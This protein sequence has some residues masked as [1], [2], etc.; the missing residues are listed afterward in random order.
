[1][2]Q[3][4]IQATLAD[5]QLFRGIETPTLEKIASL[6][7]ARILADGDAVVEQGD[8]SDSFG[9]VVEGSFE[10]QVKDE[11]LKQVRVL[12]TL[13]RGDTFGEI[14]LL[15]ETRRPASLVA[16]G[17]GKVILFDKDEFKGLV[18]DH[19]TIPLGLAEALA[20]RVRHLMR[21]G[22][23][24]TVRI[25]DFEP[26]PEVIRKLPEQVIRN[27]KVLPLKLEGERLT[28]GVVDPHD[29][30]V[31]NT[32]AAFAGG[33]EHEWV[34][35]PAEDLER[36]FE[37]D[38][39]KVFEVALEE[40]EN[41]GLLYFKGEGQVV[42]ESN[43]DAARLLDRLIQEGLDSGASDIH[44]EP[45]PD[46][47]N[48]RARIDGRMTQLHPLLGFDLYKPLVARVKVITEMDLAERRLPQDASIRIGY[49]R[50]MMDM[51]VSTLPTPTGEA[52]V[53]RLL[54]SSRRTLDLAELIID[55]TLEEAVA[56][57]FQFPS[58]LVLVT[59]PTGSGKTTTLYAGM[60]H[61]LMVNP[62]IK[63]VTAEDPVEYEL[64]GVSQV[65]VN[66]AV[67]LTYEKILRSLLRQDPDVLLI[68]EMRDQESMQIALEASLTGHL[69]L[70]SLHTNNA[71]ETISRLRQRGAEN[72]LIASALRGI[73]SQ[74]LVPRLCSACSEPAKVKPE[75]RKRLEVT[76]VLK[77]GEDFPCYQARGCSHCRSLG[78]KGR[79]ALYEVLLMT[80]ELKESIETG[81]SQGS[82]KQS[83]PAGSYLPMRR[84]ASHLLAKGL[85]AP[86]DVV[87]FFPAE[88]VHHLG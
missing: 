78:R 82:L 31:R 24:Q 14:G 10:A 66:Q 53:C 71:I 70:S 37:E 33:L 76:G 40:V 28:L 5:A 35:L 29:F 56:E 67:G 2:Q 84:Y 9:V 57:L 68:G 30:V 48:V 77:P 87:G 64:E 23:V 73:V 43:S 25:R 34:C 41:V 55:E 11:V 13:G 17:E 65:Q 80:E 26:S 74:R 8:E 4:E 50:K 58:G 42:G 81:V 36:F 46:G 75:T 39:A 19:P 1:M 15:T 51:R 49:R 47:V 38:L 83:I 6:A 12:G 22:Q 44:F 21:A 20:E 60:R 59:G 85:V 18:R 79:V 88:R 63:L 72:Y 7:E 86:E 32:V 3:S 52:V 54:D 61:R 16:R 62:T 69:V 45:D 27:Q